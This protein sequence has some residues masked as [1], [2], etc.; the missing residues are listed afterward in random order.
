MA[1]KTR[2][3]E[4]S[5]Y[6]THGLAKVTQAAEFLNTSKFTVYRLINS[7]K[8]PSIPVGGQKRIPWEVLHNHVQVKTK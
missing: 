2:T 6:P 5:P 8:L 3:T 7:E 1:R 4:P